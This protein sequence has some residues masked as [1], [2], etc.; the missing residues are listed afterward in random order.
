MQ[1]VK[2]QKSIVKCQKSIRLNFCRSVLPELLRS[3]YNCVSSCSRLRLRGRPGLMS[4]RGCTLH[5]GKTLVPY[6]QVSFSVSMMIMMRATMWANPFQSLPLLP[7]IVH[8]EFA[9]QKTRPTCVFRVSSGETQKQLLHSTHS[10][11]CRLAEGALASSDTLRIG[12]S[13]GM[14]QSLPIYGELGSGNN[15]DSRRKHQSLCLL[16]ESVFSPLP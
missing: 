6:L 8:Y 9:L 13:N 11:S 2:C 10:L 15:T 12:G 1:N 14:G 5:C 4:A 7:L 16:L 3:F